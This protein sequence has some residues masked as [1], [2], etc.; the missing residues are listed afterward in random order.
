MTYSGS[1]LLLF[2]NYNN[3][4]NRT[5]KHPLPCLY[6]IEHKKNILKMFIA[7]PG[8]YL[9]MNISS[10]PSHPFPSHPFPSQ[11]L[12]TVGNIFNLYILHILYHYII[13]W[14]KPR[15]GKIRNPGLQ[16][17]LSLPL[18]SRKYISCKY[19]YITIKIYTHTCTYIHLPTHAHPTQPPPPHT[20]THLCIAHKPRPMATISP[21]TPCSLPL[22]SHTS[23][24]PSPQPL[25][26]HTPPSPS[27]VN[28]IINRVHPAFAVIN[29]K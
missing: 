28:C 3:Q 2:S 5:F 15:L 21:P 9:N 25:L 17:F 11:A 24:L 19:T 18:I 1:I 16:S 10:C 20:H 23:P 22:P 26:L 8:L 7:C 4:T 14:K 6:Y 29:H 27:H 12:S 13:Y